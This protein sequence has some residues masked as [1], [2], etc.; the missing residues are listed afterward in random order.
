MVAILEEGRPTFE[1]QVTKPLLGICHWI[2][3]LTQ[4]NFY[5]DLIGFNTF[6]PNM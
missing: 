3:I 1:T 4:D 6:K 5:K 2:Q